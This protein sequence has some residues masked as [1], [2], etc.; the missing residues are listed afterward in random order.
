[1]TLQTRLPKVIWHSFAVSKK[2]K[3]K[4]P[5]RNALSLLHGAHC[6]IDPF[7]ILEKAEPIG[8]DYI[9]PLNLKAI[10][11]TSQSFE[12]RMLT[13]TWRGVDVALKLGKKIKVAYSGG[14]DSIAVLTAIIQHPRYNELLI[15][16]QLEVYLTSS[17][18][19]EM[20]EYFSKFILGKIPYFPMI[21]CEFGPKSDAIWMSGDFGDA[22]CSTG[23]ILP[24]ITKFG[25]A[26]LQDHNVDMIRSIYTD[27][28]MLAVVDEI[29]THCP[30]TITNSLQFSWWVEVCV[31][32]QEEMFRPYCFTEAPLVISESDS[33]EFFYRPLYQPE[34]WSR[35]FEFFGNFT[36]ARDHNDMKLELRKFSYKYTGIEKILTKRKVPSQNQIPRRCR[37]SVMF[38]DGSCVG[39]DYVDFLETIN[40]VA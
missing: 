26:A 4:T 21:F 35:A 39:P 12:D 17:S 6:L 28:K 24:V 7:G 5:I 33:S 29:A 3:E 8:S 16:D 40:G 23:Y 19:Q 10:S 15:Q 31:S 36:G 13:A 14:T 22:T 2:L 20:P 32:T 11:I 34:F 30:F 27:P 25:T 1:M 18:I 38:S 9:L 37:K